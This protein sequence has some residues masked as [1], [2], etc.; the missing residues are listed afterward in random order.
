MIRQARMEDRL[1][2]AD[3]STGPAEGARM[4][5]N[6]KNF[7]DLLT[8]QLSAQDG[9]KNSTPP[10]KQDN[11]SIPVMPL[12]MI[13]MEGFRAEKS[14]EI[15]GFVMNRP[16]DNLNGRTEAARPKE[17]ERTQAEEDGRTEAKKGED[18]KAEETKGSADDKKLDAA[19]QEAAATAADAEKIMKFLEKAL[20]GK[21]E[22][23]V[24]KKEGPVKSEN[25]AKPEIELKIRG[26]SQNAAAKFVEKVEGLLR[27]NF[28]GMKLADLRIEFVSIKKNQGT[29]ENAPVKATDKKTKNAD[30]SFMKVLNSAAANQP[31]R[32]NG[33]HQKARAADHG[34]KGEMNRQSSK[35]ESESTILNSGQAS[36]ARQ[37]QTQEVRNAGAPQPVAKIDRAAVIEQIK[38]QIGNARPADNGT[39]SVK[40]VLNPESLGRIGLEI[41]MKDGGMS[42]RFTSENAQTNDILASSSEQL[43][44]MLDEK[45]IRV[46]DIEFTRESSLSDGRGGENGHTRERE[47]S[48]TWKGDENDNGLWRTHGN[49][50]S[51]RA[52][53]TGIHPDT[54]AIS[55]QSQDI[56][57]TDE[58]N[59]RV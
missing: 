54:A 50:R 13:R 33:D 31:D 56:Y 35:K 53:T 45:G 18:E 21:I 8:G 52:D 4:E 27:E 24:S 55:E 34:H 30:Q 43:R 39:Y 19:T 11:A 17:T 29:Q 10:E 9:Q 5:K 40:M 49:E 7:L 15:E 36:N 58:I 25:A 2:F 38:S 1:G 59:F 42:A 12:A 41:V 6:A 14:T 28:P 16:E 23:K 47:G 3:A 57:G 20:A 46:T 32:A 37:N 44:Q 48:G 51:N 22:I 26:A